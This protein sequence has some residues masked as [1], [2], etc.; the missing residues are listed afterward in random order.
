MSASHMCVCVCKRLDMATALLCSFLK[1]FFVQGDR[2]SAGG[3]CPT[4]LPSALQE[5]VPAGLLGP[6]EGSLAMRFTP[7]VSF[8]VPFLDIP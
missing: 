3:L 6:S 5:N 1:P 4:K 2:G 7:F 8:G